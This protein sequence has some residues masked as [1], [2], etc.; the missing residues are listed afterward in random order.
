MAAEASLIGLWDRVL[1]GEGRR[2]RTANGRR[3]GRWE[4]EIE[5]GRGGEDA[6]G[7]GVRRLVGPKRRLGPM[8]SPVEVS[9]MFINRY[10]FCLSELKRMGKF[11]QKS[12]KTRFRLP[13]PRSKP[14][15]LSLSFVRSIKWGST[16]TFSFKIIILTKLL[17][18]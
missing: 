14:L 3:I 10:S 1:Q 18:W 12:N 6:D 2:S 7:P 13:S 15:S 5:G 8:R 16:S 17:E 11:P 4:L 9:T